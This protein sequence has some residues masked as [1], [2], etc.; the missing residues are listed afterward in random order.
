MSN[1]EELE[2]QAANIFLTTLDG[3]TSDVFSLL[4]VYFYQR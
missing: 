3:I 2:M 1:L 4:V